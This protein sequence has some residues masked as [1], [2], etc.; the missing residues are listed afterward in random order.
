MADFNLQTNG[1]YLPGDAP[2]NGSPRRFNME[3]ARRFPET[4]GSNVVIQ[5]FDMY[6]AQY[7]SISNAYRNPD[8]AYQEDPVTQR[9]MVQD[10][11]VMEPLYNQRMMSVALLEG[12]V[13]AEDED[14]EQQKA[15]ATIITKVVNGI[16][17]FVKFK[18][19]LLWAIWY[20]RA[21]TEHLW[22]WDKDYESTYADALKNI[23]DDK[24]RRMLKMRSWTPVQGDKLTMH[25]KTGWLGVRVRANS[26]HATM[27]NAVGPEGRIRWIRGKD[28]E[29]WAFHRHDIVDSDFFEPAKA[30][31]IAGLGLRERVW[32]TW[33]FKQ[34]V[35]QWTLEWVQRLGTGFTIWFFEADNPASEAK[36]RDAAERQKQGTQIL[37]PRIGDGTR[38]PG[39]ERIEA[40]TAGAQFLDQLVDRYCND[41][42]MMIAGNTLTAKTGPTG[43]GSGV[44]EQHANTKDLIRRY[45]AMNLDETLTTDVVQVIQRWCFPK[46]K[47]NLR[48]QSV[49]EKPDVDALMGAADK[50]YNWGAP[51][52]EDWAL[53]TVGIPK[54]KKGEKTLSKAKQEM[55]GQPQGMGGGMGAPP[56]GGQD[57]EQFVMDL[58]GPGQGEEGEPVGAGAE[59]EAA[60]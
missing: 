10:A 16:P 5:P 12:E 19:A 29:N 7:Q 20:G 42:R 25:Q 11:V 1:L 22:A 57:D 54:P 8:V 31:S 28:R 58:L 18:M 36:V 15:A 45:D 46:I 17:S 41:I 40:S 32:W 56:S 44:A 13:K 38:G 30:G 52:P 47:A 21:A 9:A 48:Y 27:D 4:P 37:F 33:Y 55:Q 35:V 34:L 50:L 2:R 51:I 6:V 59:A 53:E 60:L 43:L 26:Q 24:P 23:K 39:I 49:I 14:D 3:N